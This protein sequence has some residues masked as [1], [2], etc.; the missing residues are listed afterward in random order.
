MFCFSFL[1]R[2]KRQQKQ[3]TVVEKEA[4]R[5]ANAA[6]QRA[7]RERKRIERL[8]VKHCN[9]TDFRILAE[10]FFFAKA[11]E[12]NTADVTMTEKSV[13]TDVTYFFAEGPEKI[14]TF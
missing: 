8:Y 7:S 14:P 11:P 13:M 10:K 12:K 3:L 1:G 6:W 5:R 9:H 4:K 2:S